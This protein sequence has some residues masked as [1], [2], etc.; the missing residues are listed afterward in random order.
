MIHWSLLVQPPTDRN[1][2]HGVDTTRYV[3]SS[4]HADEG[5]YEV[6]AEPQM[7]SASSYD[8]WSQEAERVRRVA[9]QTGQ[10]L[11]EGE[12]HQ[13]DIYDLRALRVELERADRKHRTLWD[14]LRQLPMF[15]S[16]LMRKVAGA[17]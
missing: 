13:L 7:V 12:L 4:Q 17:R 8:A 10:Q 6:L 16:T 9:A 11:D 2:R 1:A 14:V 5:V 15:G 3:L